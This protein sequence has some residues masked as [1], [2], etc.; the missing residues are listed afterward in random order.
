MSFYQKTEFRFDYASECIY[1]YEVCFG[2]D[3]MRRRKRFPPQG[4]RRELGLVLFSA[5]CGMIIVFLLPCWGIIAAGM[6]I[7]AGAYLLFFPC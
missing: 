5:G 7:V 6:L 4:G 2:G 3:I 1:W